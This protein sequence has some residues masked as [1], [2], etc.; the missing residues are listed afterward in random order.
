MAIDDVDNDDYNDDDG[1]RPTELN[2]IDAT[3]Y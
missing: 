1:V 2:V 3:Q